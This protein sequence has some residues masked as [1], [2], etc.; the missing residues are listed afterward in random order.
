VADQ[1]AGASAVREEG[2]GASKVCVCGTIYPAD[3]A[4]CHHPY[5]EWGGQFFTVAAADQHFADDRSHWHLT[6]TGPLTGQE[7]LDA[8]RAAEWTRRSLRG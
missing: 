2:W 3:Q 6:L 8:A 7:R 4:P 5:V 1:G